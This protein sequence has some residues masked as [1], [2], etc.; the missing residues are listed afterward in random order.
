VQTRKERV[1]EAL[2][3]RGSRRL[4]PCKLFGSM[5]ILRC[6][7][8][9]TL[10]AWLQFPAV[11]NAAPCAE[12]SGSFVSIAMT[13]GGESLR[14]EI[15][16]DLAAELARD[17]IV[18]CNA[19]G[20]PSKPIAQIEITINPSSASIRIEDALTSKQV[21][22][23]VDLPAATEDVIALTVAL[24]TDELLR[25]SW[26]EL[27]VAKRT[28]PPVPTPKAVPTPPKQPPAPSAE[29]LPMNELGVRTVV[30]WF[31]V[32][33]TWLGAELYYRREIVP[34]LDVELSAL[35]RGG[36]PVTSAHGSVDGFSAGGGAALGLWPIRS[37]AVRLGA[38]FGTELVYAR[39][40]GRAEAGAVEGE[41]DGAAVSL[42]GGIGLGLD[43][44]PARFSTEI[45]VGAPVAS[46][47]GEDNAVVVAGISGVMVRAHLGIGVLF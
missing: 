26:A 19:D 22:R 25:A 11:A 5:R 31:G 6:A 15:D 17:N 23:S 7:F 32:G 34:I 37:S 45:G 16:K 28:A 30:A 24:A 27:A 9:L 13:G 8:G 39:L 36:L 29:E 1:S 2:S 33:H 21:S 20:S 44:T 47:V 3:K 38:L 42:R 10:L 35:W 46:V 43:V 12:F 4:G 41:V 18:T 40:S 14:Q